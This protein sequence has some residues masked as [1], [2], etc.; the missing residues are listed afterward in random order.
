ML[1]QKIRQRVTLAELDE[2]F[3]RAASAHTFEGDVVW[4]LTRKKRKQG[5]LKRSELA[6]LP[7]ELYLRESLLASQLP[8][9]RFAD[10][11]ATTGQKNDSA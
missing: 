7:N 9:F 5:L 8:D 6:M 2:V 4:Q 11:A 3:D 1:G 10:D